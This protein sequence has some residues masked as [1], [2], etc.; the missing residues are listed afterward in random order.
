MLSS[1]YRGCDRLTEGLLYFAIVFGPWAFG[2]TQDWSVH[3]M[4]GVGLTLGLLW[5]I[6][7]ALR[8]TSASD[9][10]RQRTEDR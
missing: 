4:N 3:V 1:L 5:L 2:T 8:T 10:G 6:K 9:D 7:L